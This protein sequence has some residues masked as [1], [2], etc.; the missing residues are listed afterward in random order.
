[1]KAKFQ[2]YL[3]NLFRQP[4]VEKFQTTRRRRLTA[5]GVLFCQ[6]VV[7]GCLLL[8]TQ[9]LVWPVIVA[10][11][12]MIY[13]MGMLNLSTR[14]IFELSDVHLDEFQVCVRDSAYRKSY[15]FALLWLLLVA[16]IFGLLE[17]SEKANHFG[18]AFV[19]LGFFWGMSAPRV[20]VAWTM[21]A[22]A[23]ED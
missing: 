13:L 23:L 1:M 9:D 2:S 6:F 15:F 3:N 17:G 12:F 20:L 22:D 18:F 11:V 4:L 10:G 5:V 7:V 21:P 8:L 16:P 14:G 19:L